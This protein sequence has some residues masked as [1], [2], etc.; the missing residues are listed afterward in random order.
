MCSKRCDINANFVTIHKLGFPFS[1]L[2]ASQSTGQVNSAIPV[3]ELGRLTQDRMLAAPEQLQHSS[4]GGLFGENHS[5]STDCQV[6][7][8]D[9]TEQEV[10]ICWSSGC[11]R[12]IK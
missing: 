11:Q 10:N 9:K 6:C 3:S 8:L 7:D 2:S 1:P 4:R 5:Y 12:E